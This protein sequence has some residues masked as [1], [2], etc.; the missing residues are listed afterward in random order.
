M[1]PGWPTTRILSHDGR[2][3]RVTLRSAGPGNAPEVRLWRLRKELD[4][5]LRD[6]CYVPCNKGSVLRSHTVARIGL[7][8]LG[9]P[10]WVPTTNRANMEFASDRCRRNLLEGVND[11][12]K[13]A[14]GL[15]THHLH[16]EQH[17]HQEP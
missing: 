7:A 3:L 17:R 5:E 15:A 14:V 8:G 1:V 10:V 13:Q 11:P 12:L 2:N 16:D 6:G 4:L 9:G